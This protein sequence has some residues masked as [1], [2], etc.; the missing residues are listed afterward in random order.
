M[1][2]PAQGFF[3]TVDGSLLGFKFRQLGSLWL[4]RGEPLERFLT[5]VVQ[6]QGKGMAVFFARKFDNNLTRSLQDTMR[7]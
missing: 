6:F 5:S 7:L 4:L 1:A 2:W 3:L